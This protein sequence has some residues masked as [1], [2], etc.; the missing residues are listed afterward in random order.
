MMIQLFE[1]THRPNSVVRNYKIIQMLGMG[2]YGIT[3]LAENELTREKVVLKQLRKRALK[4]GKGLQSF[5]YEKNILL[6]LN[7]SAIPKYIED[8]KWKRNYFIVMEFKEGR[9]FEQEIF[10]NKQKYSE[11]EAFQYLM[12]ASSIVKYVHEKGIVHR[13]LRIPNLLIHEGEIFVIDFG[14]ARNLHDDDQRVENFPIEKQLMREV[15]IESDFYALG[16]FVLF[17]LYSSFEPKGIEKSWE[18]ELP[19]SEEAKRVIRKLLMID[20]AYQSAEEL[21][22]DIQ[23]NVLGGKQHVI[24]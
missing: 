18:D 10:E 13:D 4:N 3:Y 15:K 9:T 12:K 19:L 20:Q 23:I 1:K 17:L 14:L 11:T 8:F 2:S 24:L 6:T 7:H 5:R 22:Q 16:H 21:I